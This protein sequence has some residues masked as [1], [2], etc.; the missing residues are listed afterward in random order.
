MIQSARWKI[1][2]VS[3]LVLALVSCG[4][5]GGPSDGGAAPTS[6]SG[7]T[8][9]AP[10]AA[11]PP[12]PGT[13]AAG[14][15]WSDPAT[16]GGAVPAAGAKIKIAAGQTVVL[17]TA[18]ANLA[19]L[20][21]EGQLIADADKDVAITADYV[22]VAGSGALL[23][24][25][26][27]EKP[28]TRRATITLT[29]SDPSANVMGMGT[30]YLGATM[31]ATVR[32]VGNT[33][34]TLSWTRLAATGRPGERSI[35]L[36]GA[37]GWKVGDEIVLAPSDYNPDEATTRRIASISE[38][39]VTLD[40][41]LVAQH[42]GEQETHGGMTIDMRAEVGL[43]TRNIVIR[44][45]VSGASDS[46]G[47]HVMFMRDAKAQI[48]GV[49]FTQLGQ[50]GRE[51]RYPVHFHLMRDTAQGSYLRN[52][53]L[54]R[55]FQR[56]ITVHSSNNLTIENNVA[57]R[58]VGHCVFLE[59]GNE[60]NN[61]F[62]GNLVVHVSNMPFN[63]RSKSPGW[64]EA[65][66]PAGQPLESPVIV[67]CDVKHDRRASAFW[68]TNRNNRFV[69]NVAAGVVEGFGYWMDSPGD[70]PKAVDDETGADIAGQAQQ[71]RGL[72]E[73]RDNAAHSLAHSAND[74]NY[75][76]KQS[77]SCF[78][79]DTELGGTIENFTAYKCANS[80]VWTG[81]NTVLKGARLADNQKAV[82]RANDGLLQITGS[83]VIGES[84]NRGDPATAQQVF[85]RHGGPRGI[86][87]S[88]T[89]ADDVV[90]ANFANA[91]HDN[92]AFLDER[93]T[94]V[95]YVRGTRLVN[96]FPYRTRCNGLTGY[97]YNDRTC[98]LTD[99]TGGVFGP[100]PASAIVANT[101]ST[102]ARGPECT[103]RNELGVGQSVVLCP[104]GVFRTLFGKE[105]DASWDGA[106]IV[107]R[108][109]DGMSA[110]PQLYSGPFGV[111]N[112]ELMM[113]TH[114]EYQMSVGQMPRRF[115]IQPSGA[116]NQYL[117][118]N[119]DLKRP[120]AAVYYND[121]RIEYGGF[122]D[123]HLKKP[124]A[125]LASLDAVRASTKD[126]Y[127]VD[128]IGRVFLRIYGDRN[129]WVCADAQCSR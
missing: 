78:T 121:F 43:L 30:K 15:R 111:P 40:R 74:P 124:L 119:M 106:A 20:V 92:A 59:D 82:F 67:N 88:D 65:M 115:W 96:T 79:I 4:G 45:A 9:P 114:R 73:F 75:P 46:F 27:A 22:L 118:L 31:G 101:K 38:R 42:W 72:L 83:L 48:D 33:A 71:P 29:G 93:G 116:S 2:C 99:A 23:Q 97:D 3:V 34:D 50:L 84:R 36:A 100:Q 26:S 113:A 44:G 103:E 68:I 108:R 117:D 18:T 10:G 77:S 107:L 53:S 16:W 112:R 7:T 91:T 105:D 6:G 37:P 39:T 85:A 98:Y 55:N 89:V 25:G 28:F 35:T 17:D 110:T 69:G 81:H 66:C 49:E 56:C 90:L 123:E 109:P 64:T 51:G 94:K 5:G 125:R 1:A 128:A 32:I 76:G 129:V 60:E 14:S 62:R 12:S 13:Q 95:S 86:D 41:P 63:K 120:Q 47:G 87:A 58:A 122:S 70:Q 104:H 52:A 102:F 11:S 19:A 57:Y 8:T 127:F 80:G 61:T 54:H 24:I 21:I 126:A